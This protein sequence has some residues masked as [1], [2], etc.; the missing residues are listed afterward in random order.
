M[1]HAEQGKLGVVGLHAS[2]GI[3]CWCQVVDAS[4]VETY[5]SLVAKMRPW[6][7]SPSILHLS[8]ALKTL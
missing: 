3:L 6:A 4:I 8:T 7:H 1:R 5:M 2:Q